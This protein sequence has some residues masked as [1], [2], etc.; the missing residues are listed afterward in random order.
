[1]APGENEFDTPAAGQ[2]PRA[3]PSK[4]LWPHHVSI[5]TVSKGKKELQRHVISQKENHKVWAKSTA[6]PT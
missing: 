3:G 6:T 5:K 1:M 2:D 4:S